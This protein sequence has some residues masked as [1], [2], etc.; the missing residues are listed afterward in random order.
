MVD[1]PTSVPGEPTFPA[2]TSPDKGSSEGVNANQEIS[3]E[4]KILNQINEASGRNYASLEE[5]ISGVKETYSFVGSE[6]MQEMQRLA[7]AGEKVLSRQKPQSSGERVEQLARQLEEI[8]FT[9]SYPEAK[10]I[11]SLVGDIASKRNLSWEDA[12]TQTPEGKKLQKLV[13]IE[14]KE[15]E[16]ANPATVQSG[17]RLFGE[18]R[19]IT[20]DEFSKLPLEEQRK[21]VSKLPT[22]EKIFPKGQYSSG[23]RT[24]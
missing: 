23:K 1:N 21:I 6:A 5:A 15:Q 12:Y 16:A 7:K 22:Y 20:R 14:R 17:Q 13:E 11:A 19:A 9:Q 3:P 18:G 8:R 10:S 4:Q 24:G 2:D